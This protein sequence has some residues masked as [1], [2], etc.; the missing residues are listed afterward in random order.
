MITLKQNG[1]QFIEDTQ[2]HVVNKSK[3]DD[4]HSRTIQAQILTL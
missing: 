1:T 3:V 4:D 2:L